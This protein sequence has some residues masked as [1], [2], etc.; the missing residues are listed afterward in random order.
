MHYHRPRRRKDADLETD[1]FVRARLAGDAA[2][3]PTVETVVTIADP[4]EAAGLRAR[5]LAA[6]VGL[7]RQAVEARRVH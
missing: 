5:Q 6:I 4:L 7:L 3:R 2:R 1:L